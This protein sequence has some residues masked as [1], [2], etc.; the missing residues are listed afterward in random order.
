MDRLPFDTVLIEEEP[1]RP[2]LTVEEFLAIPL[3]VRV[4]LIME[5]RLRFFR[6]EA[7]IELGVGLRGL[8]NAARRPATV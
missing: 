5:K 2:A 7:A 6:G 3:G 4:R 8:M 1:A